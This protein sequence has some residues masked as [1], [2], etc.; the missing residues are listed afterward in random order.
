[1]DKLQLA[2]LYLLSKAVE[3]PAGEPLVRV[4]AQ[5]TAAAQR[6]QIFVAAV[7]FVAL[8]SRRA[9]RFVHPKM[10]GGDDDPDQALASRR[11]PGR[12]KLAFAIAPA[13]C[14]IG[15][16]AELATI[17]I[18]PADAAADVFPVAGI[19]M[20]VSHGDACPLLG[21]PQADGKRGPPRPAPYEGPQADPR[22]AVRPKRER[23]AR[24]RAGPAL[25]FRVA[26]PALAALG[27]LNGLQDGLRFPG[28][29]FWHKEI[30]D[31]ALDTGRA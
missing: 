6:R 16:A 8:V 9:I 18:P 10:R 31:I 20:A 30:Y 11:A 4:V 19:T 14:T 2:G 22:Q 25:S 28:N 12:V 5:M 3:G 15:Q 27:R 13:R 24:G 26:P 17:A 23:G 21:G 29:L 1:M 7:Q